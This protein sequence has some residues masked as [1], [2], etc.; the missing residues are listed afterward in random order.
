MNN[1]LR[2]LAFFSGVGILIV[3]MY[4]SQD[5]FNFDVAGDSGYGTMAIFIGWFL[6][7]VVSIVQFVFSSNFKDLNPSLIL[8]G[9]LAYV[10]SIYTNYEGILH[11]QGAA[12]SIWGARVLAIVMDGVAEP[13]IAWGL[14]ESLTGDFIG[15]FIKA[16]FGAPS[17]IQEQNKLKQVSLRKDVEKP[18]EV[19]KI[20]K[21]MLKNLGKSGEDLHGVKREKPSR[22]DL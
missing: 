15:N 8:F 9:V 4:W 12:T 10:Y 3:S 2:K 19:R 7:V 13:L 20:P 18:E 17:K 11:F 16:V 6:A 22:Y 1:V 14:Y 21:E 5:G